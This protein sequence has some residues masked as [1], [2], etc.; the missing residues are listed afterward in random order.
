MATTEAFNTSAL[1]VLHEEILATI[2]QAA[3]HLEQFAAGTAAPGALPQAIAS[4]RQLRGVVRLVEL[5]GIDILIDEVLLLLGTLSLA[6]GL[7]RQKRVRRIEHCFAYLTR[8]LRFCAHSGQGLPY[9]LLP[10]INDLR[11]CQGQKTF[12]ENY[13]SKR[14]SNAGVSTRPLNAGITAAP[15]DVQVQQVR[16]AHQLFQAGLVNVLKDNQVEASLALMVRALESVRHNSPHTL[17][18]EVFEAVELVLRSILVGDLKLIPVR[19][20]LLRRIER[21]IKLFQQEELAMIDHE[22]NRALVQE[23]NH[24][25]QISHSKDPRTQHYLRRNMLSAGQYSDKT[26]RAKVKFLRGDRAQRLKVGGQEISN[27]IR[28]L[29]TQIEMAM[30]L[31]QS[32]VV[33]TPIWSLLQEIIRVLQ[34]AGLDELADELLGEVSQYIEWQGAAPFMQQQHLSPLVG[35]LLYVETSIHDLDKTFVSYNGEIVS[36]LVRDKFVSSAEF[37]EAERIVIGEIEE[38]FATIKQALAD[39]VAKDFDKRAIAQLQP[40]FEAL[41]GGALVLGLSRAAQL[42]NAC[43]GFVEQELLVQPPHISLHY[44][45]EVYADALVSLEYYIDTI[46]LN[47]NADTQALMVA[48]ES[49]A[50]LG[51]SL[52]S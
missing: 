25:L 8:Y 2:R 52:E 34:R 13:F 22:Q 36:A 7:E 4:M 42:I 41:R 46:K 48:Q 24:L 20:L 29:K 9:L 11:L 38:A 28:T 51:F 32:P 50:A 30:A 43:A 12:P 5:R 1:H 45:L 18:V 15:T 37:V 27:A 49:L 44:L 3:S 26:L 16:R 47:R 35:L 23:L 10:A 19:K 6:D 39:F 17:I 33:V 40:A 31:E 21:E 14:D